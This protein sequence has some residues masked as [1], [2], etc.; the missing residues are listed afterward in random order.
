MVKEL[1]GTP[2]GGSTAMVHVLTLVR[3]FGPRCDGVGGFV[4]IPDPYG[5]DLI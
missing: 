3:F 1:D 4:Q 5:N 2:V